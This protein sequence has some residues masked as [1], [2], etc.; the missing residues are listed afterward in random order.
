MVELNHHSPTDDDGST[1]SRT[2][3]TEEDIN[4]KRLRHG[5]FFT[6]TEEIH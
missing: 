1:D 4:W 6:Y 5:Q 2:A 3:D